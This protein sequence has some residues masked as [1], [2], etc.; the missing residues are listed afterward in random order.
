MLFL[1]F[2]ALAI[3][4]RLEPPHPHTI[5]RLHGLHRIDH[6]LQLVDPIGR[7]HRLSGVH[8]PAQ[9]F[10]LVGYLVEEL[11][12]QVYLLEEVRHRLVLLRGETGQIRHWVWGVFVLLGLFA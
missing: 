1:R 2:L 11:S 4:G 8:V 5:G 3:L 6:F 10:V 7:V 9:E 12:V